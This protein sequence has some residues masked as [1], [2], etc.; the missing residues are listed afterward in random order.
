MRS[1]TEFGNEDDVPTCESAARL[2]LSFSR[3]QTAVLANLVFENAAVQ[4]MMPNVL[5]FSP[6]L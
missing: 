3:S 2:F 5:F 1:Q 4:M 6:A